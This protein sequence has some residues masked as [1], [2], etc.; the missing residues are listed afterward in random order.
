M[1]YIQHEEM[2]LF[3]TSTPTSNLHTK[4][5]RTVHMY[6]IIAQESIEI[7]IISI[8]KRNLMCLC[9]KIQ[10]KCYN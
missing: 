9:N 4:R 2:V 3:E 7:K 1:Q 8:Y 10:N 5:I 6:D